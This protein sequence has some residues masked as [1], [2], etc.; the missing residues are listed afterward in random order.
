M[1]EN[2]SPIDVEGSCS[3]PQPSVETQICADSKKKVTK[4]KAVKPRSEV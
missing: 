3:V 1:E 4:R 2:R